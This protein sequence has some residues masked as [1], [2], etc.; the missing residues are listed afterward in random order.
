MLITQKYHSAQDIDPEFIPTLEQLLSDCVP[1]FEWLKDYEKEAPKNVYF[2]YYLFFSHK[3]NAPIGFAQVAIKKESTPKSSIFAKFNKKAQ[4]KSKEANWIVPGS[5][6]EAIVFN[7]SYKSVGLT[8]A[9]HIFQEFEQREDIKGQTIRFGQAYRELPN[10]LHSKIQ[11]QTEIIVPD[12]LVKNQEDYQNYIHS[13]PETMRMEIMKNWKQLHK[14]SLKLDE[15][16]EFKEIFAYKNQGAKLY[17]ELKQNPKVKKY[18][19]LNT[20][21]FTIESNKQLLGIVFLIKGYGHHYFYDF[22]QLEENL[23]QTVFHQ[24]AIMNFYE[25]EKSNR[26]HLLFQPTNHQ[27]FTDV[28]FT[29]RKQ[30][31]MTYKNV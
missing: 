27:Y 24:I 4:Q 15:N 11:K 10:Q 30:I 8:K 20:K 9:T 12:T 14:L 17:K 3:T 22:I 31:E 18:I 1:S 29:F 21:Y 28:G 13:L 5:F 6:Q 2:N 23:D 16:D 25:E 19:K 7:P 26:L